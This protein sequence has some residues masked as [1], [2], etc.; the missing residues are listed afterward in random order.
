M[1]IRA[2]TVDI[3]RLSQLIEQ[4]SPAPWRFDTEGY[5][6]WLEF[7]HE[8]ADGGWQELCEMTEVAPVQD[9]DAELIAELRNAAPELIAAY[10]NLEE[11]KALLVQAVEAIRLT[12]EYVGEQMLPMVPGWSWYDAVTAINSVIG[13]VWVPEDDA[14]ARRLVLEH[15]DLK[16]GLVPEVSNADD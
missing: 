7:E 14:E 15:F 4:A 12:R 11:L 9:A 5:T 2:M 3:E 6:T 13:P 10:R 1:D 16:D 8:G